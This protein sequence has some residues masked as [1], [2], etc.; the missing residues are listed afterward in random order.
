MDEV[1]P[2]QRYAKAIWA[3]IKERP[4]SDDIAGLEYR[5]VAFAVYCTRRARGE[6]VSSLLRYLDP[7]F[8]ADE[9]EAAYA[10][11]QWLKT[12]FGEDG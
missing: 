7:V 3:A 2:S 10:A 11:Y 9:A 8:E 6:K 1:S 5:H 12:C 4:T